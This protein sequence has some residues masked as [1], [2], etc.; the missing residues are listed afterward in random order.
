METLNRSWFLGDLALPL[1]MDRENGEAR[2]SLMSF[3]PN[4]AP[5]REGTNFQFGGKIMLPKEGSRVIVEVF[6]RNPPVRFESKV[7]SLSDHAISIAAPSLNGKKMAVP[8][9]TQIRLSASSSNGVIQVNTRVDRIQTTGGVRWLLHDPGITGISHVDRRCLS[10]IRVDRPIGWS[11]IDQD[12]RK[13][14]EGPMRLLN[15]NSGGALVKVYQDLA[16]DQEVILDLTE[17]VEEED[18]MGLDEFVIPAKVVRLACLNRYG[19]KLGCLTGETRMLFLKTLH[20]IERRLL[21]ETSS[22][23]SA[24]PVHS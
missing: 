2:L 9:G 16:M 12:K 21:N 18:R 23:H 4:L 24:V 20:R 22:F 8:E 5:K 14:G 17:L 7:V 10:R 3:S 1:L 19:L 13:T 6:I 11:I 15:I